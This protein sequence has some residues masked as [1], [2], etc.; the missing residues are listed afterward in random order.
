M[1]PTMKRIT[2]QYFIQKHGNQKPRVKRRLMTMRPIKH[3]SLNT[4]TRH[5]GK[6]MLCRHNQRHPRRP[7]HW[8]PPNST[9]T[10]SQTPPLLPTT[11]ST[12]QTHQPETT[13]NLPDASQKA[14]PYYST[15]LAKNAPPLPTSAQKK[16][17]NTPPPS[18]HTPPS[19]VT[20]QTPLSIQSLFRHRHILTHR[21]PLWRL[22]LRPPRRKPTQLHAINQ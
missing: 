13:D 17:P 12:H 1:H 21:Q 9:P 20:S 5:L 16:A 3:R 7:R 22:L 11:R 8:A 15:Y 10:P 2:R 6:P 4:Y 18:H 14:P 19:R